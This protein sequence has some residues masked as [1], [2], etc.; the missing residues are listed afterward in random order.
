MARRL[1]HA[2]GACAAPTALGAVVQDLRARGGSLRV[3]GFWREQNLDAEIA[4]HV[5]LHGRRG[6]RASAGHQQDDER[7]VDLVAGAGIE[8]GLP[9]R[10]VIRAEVEKFGVELEFLCEVVA[11]DQARQVPIRAEM[12]DVV[13]NLP[14]HV[15]GPKLFFEFDGK[16]KARAA[17]RDSADERVVWIVHRSLGEDADFETV[18]SLIE[19]SPF[20]AQ[21]ILLQPVFRIARWILNAQPGALIGELDARAETKID[22]HVRC[23]GGGIIR[24]EEWHVANINFPIEIAGGDGV[25]RKIRRPALRERGRATEREE[26]EKYAGA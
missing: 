24:V 25:S 16:E 11:D 13:A 7:L 10:G 1:R 17:R 18:L 3:V 26:S 19:E 21:N 5:G 6:P 8:S 23:V 20:D 15:H 12:N 4:D 9:F 2:A 14:I 22:V